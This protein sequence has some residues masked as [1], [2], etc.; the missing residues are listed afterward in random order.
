MSLPPASFI[1]ILTPRLLGRDEA[2]GGPGL[3]EGLSVVIKEAERVDHSAPSMGGHR[4]N[5][6]L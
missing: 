1:G 6:P 2:V 4:K 3:L 5:P